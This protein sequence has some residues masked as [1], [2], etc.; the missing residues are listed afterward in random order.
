LGAVAVGGCA[1]GARIC[2][3][4]GDS[5]S[6]PAAAAG[7]GWLDS[8]GLQRRQVLTG[9]VAALGGSVG[10]GRLV[11]LR[12]G[13]GL[14]RGDG[15]R[16]VGFGAAGGT[17][18]LVSIAFVDESQQGDRFA[19]GA[20]VVQNPG[21]FT[22]NVRKHRQATKDFEEFTY[23]SLS[24]R[25]ARTRGRVVE[26]PSDLMGFL[27][28]C[29]DPAAPG[30][31]RLH[32]GEWRFALCVWESPPAGRYS[33][34]LAHVLGSLWS[35]TP[36][37]GAGSVILDQID[38]KRGSAEPE[39]TVRSTVPEISSLLPL[40]SNACDGLQAVDL[41]LGVSLLEHANP[42]RVQQRTP[43]STQHL[44]RHAAALCGVGE[45]FCG[46]PD[47]STRFLRVAPRS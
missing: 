21:A 10:N 14:H 15:S 20:L 44:H 45:S 13:W 6:A 27:T 29:L 12:T 39:R 23:K 5:G 37:L 19:F 35:T 26:P 7:R 33:A 1:G 18:C 24:A 22:T 36:W 9:P 28:C 41:L 16:W 30:R 46:A 4:C 17:L 42:A 38:L 3:C 47:Q 11:V 40:P 34:R 32:P 8:A 25:R 2:R 31:R 43:D